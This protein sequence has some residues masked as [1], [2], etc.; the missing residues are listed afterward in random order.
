MT[1]TVIAATTAVV[2]LWYLARMT[3]LVSDLQAVTP[4]RALAW[5]PKPLRSWAVGLGNQLFA[6]GFTEKVARNAWWVVM[7]GSLLIA[8]TLAAVSGLPFAVLPSVL[9][10]VP[11]ATT[12]VLLTLQLRNI[13]DITTYLPMFTATFRSESRT[14]SS[15][16]AF[17]LAMRELRT[18]DIRRSR[19]GTR[20]IVKVYR[21]LQPVLFAI[22]TGGLQRRSLADELRALKPSLRIPAMRQYVED[23]AVAAETSADQRDEILRVTAQGLELQKDAAAKVVVATQPATMTF[24]IGVVAMPFLLSQAFALSMDE[25]AT[26]F[27]VFQASPMWQLTIVA[28]VAVMLAGVELMRRISDRMRRVVPT[29]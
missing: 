8:V 17:V 3:T 9:L 20:G 25:N 24:I 21:E 18:S 2:L 7:G 5:L 19:G 23:L 13:R 16:D 22:E 26:G 15:E 27:D 28:G 1:T 14:R 11:V 12:R 6:V 4:A 10:I 29:A